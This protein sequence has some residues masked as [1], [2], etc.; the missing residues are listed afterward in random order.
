VKENPEKYTLRQ[1]SAKRRGLHDILARAKAARKELKK[2]KKHKKNSKAHKKKPSKKEEDNMRASTTDPQARNMKMPNGG[3]SPAYNMQFATDAES[4]A[5]VGVETL[6]EGNDSNQ[7]TPMQKQLQER[8]GKVPDKTLVDAGYGS[9]SDIKSASKN[10][11]LYMPC[12]KFAD[13]NELPEIDEMKKRMETPEAKQ[14]YKARGS[15]AEFVNARVRIRGLRQVLVS[16]LRKV[17]TVGTLFALAHNM[18]C[19]I[20]KLKKNI[21]NAP[22]EPAI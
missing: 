8:F 19:W 21:Q 18:L 20:S 5:I 1:A 15:L 3:F 16:G 6:Q 17:Q 2:Y 12:D 4:G 13:K 11:I 14:I 9:F 10:T 22:L 7:I